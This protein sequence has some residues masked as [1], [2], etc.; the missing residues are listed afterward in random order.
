[1]NENYIK[2]LSVCVCDSY[3]V[4]GVQAD[5]TITIAIIMGEHRFECLHGGG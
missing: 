2:T 5:N 3:G 4:G 1:M